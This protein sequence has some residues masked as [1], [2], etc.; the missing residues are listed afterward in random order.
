MSQATTIS[1]NP[2]PP[3]FQSAHVQDS[4][5]ASGATTRSY[6][7]HN[8][9]WVIVIGMASFFGVAALILAGGWQ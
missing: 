6:A 8:P 3:A 1:G 4:P 5:V 7:I 2:L 9:L